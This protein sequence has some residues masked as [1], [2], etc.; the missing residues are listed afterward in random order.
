MPVELHTRATGT[1]TAAPHCRLAAAYFSLPRPRSGGAR[2]KPGKAEA[3]A[4][5]LAATSLTPPQAQIQRVAIT[6]RGHAACEARGCASAPTTSNRV[7][8]FPVHLTHLL[9]P[10][11]LHGGGSNNS[12][13]EVMGGGFRRWRTSSPTP[14]RSS[15]RQRRLP[16]SRVPPSVSRRHARLR[17]RCL[18]FTRRPRA[19]AVTREPNDAADA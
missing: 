3:E 14:P 7:A 1:R 16:P 12:Q 13:I 6:R 2:S 5:R 10:C 17:R 19:R 9:L 4:A 11:L 18:L 15:P 8:S